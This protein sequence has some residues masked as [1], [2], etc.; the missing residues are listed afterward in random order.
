MCQGRIESPD[1]ETGEER[2]ATFLTPGAGDRRQAAGRVHVD[3]AVVTA[4]ESHAE[5]E[6]ALGG[7]SVE[8][9]K[10]HNLRRV[11]PGDLRRPFR[12]PA[13]QVCPHIGVEIGECGEIVLVRQTV[14]QHYLHHR[15][16]QRRISA[17]PQ[18]QPEIGGGHG[19]R[20]VDVD[21]DQLR[22]AR[23][24]RLLDV[25]HQVDMGVNRIATPHDDQVR[26]LDFH[27][28]DTVLRADTGL[29]TGDR[30]GDADRWVEAGV[31]KSAA[32]PVDPVALQ[33]AEGAARVKRPDGFRAVG[34]AGRTKGRRHGV[35]RLV[36]ADPLE[37]AF[38]FRA[39]AAQRM[40]QAIRVMHP[41][42]IAPDFL[43]DHTGRERQ[44]GGTADAPDRGRRQ[45]LD[46][47]RA[48]ARAIMGAGGFHDLHGHG[49][50]LR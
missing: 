48:G 18:H 45:T 26:R 20:A 17:G 1:V 4:G 9:G 43:A 5:A 13:R 33:D 24:A 29:P 16:G 42:R 35:Q 41:L 11:E 47:E 12:S 49:G 28:V 3:G 50:I 31:T 8:P 25:A 23:L 44:V 40:G 36:P 22:A 46:L 10:I 38:S 21:D 6:V 34:C 2:A 27:R 32:E 7:R 14:R 19:R 37:T 15:A 30:R 39:D